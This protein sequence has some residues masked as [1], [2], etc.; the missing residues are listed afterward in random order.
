MKALTHKKFGRE[1]PAEG[2]ILN[3]E[4]ECRNGEVCNKQDY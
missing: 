1:I 4:K 2:I 3:K